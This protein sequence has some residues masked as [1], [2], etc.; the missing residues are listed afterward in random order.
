[1]FKSGFTSERLIF[2][3][4]ISRSLS[5]ATFQCDRD[6]RALSHRHF[7]PPLIYFITDS[8]TYSVPLLLKRRF[9]KCDRTTG[10]ALQQRHRRLHPQ[11]QDQPRRH[12]GPLRARPLRHQLVQRSGAKGAKLAQELGYL[13]AMTAIFLLEYRGPI[14]V[15]CANLTPFLRQLF[16]S[17][18]SRAPE[19]EDTAFFAEYGEDSPGRW[20]HSDARLVYTLYGES[21]LRYTTRRLNGSTVRAFRR[22]LGIVCNDNRG[23]NIRI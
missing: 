1:M 23:R 17:E 21:L 8:R 13:V 3:N 2:K 20:G 6:A 15:F 11:R 9:L 4:I 14:C 16:R 22:A 5:E 19:V 10:R 18:S 12:R 7:V